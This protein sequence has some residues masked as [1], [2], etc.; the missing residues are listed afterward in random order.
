MR[1][2]L[3]AV[4]A[5]V[6]ALGLSAAL[7]AASGQPAGEAIRALL[8]GGTGSV[9]AFLGSASRATPLLLTGP[10]VAVALTAGR[11]NIGAEGQLAVGALVAATTAANLPLP[12]PLATAVGLILGAVSGGLWAIP[13]SW[14]RERRGI[15]EVITTLLL[16]YVARN[17]T[18]FLASGPW[19]E[20]SGQAPQTAAIPWPLPRLD[21]SGGVHVGL[22]IALPVAIVVSVALAHSVA[23][24]E[25]RWVGA[26][27]EAARRAGIPVERWRH[28]AFALSGA[29][30]GLAGGLVVCG[31]TP[32]RRFPADF[33]GVGYGF[34]G[35]AIAL[36]AA[37]SPLALAPVAFLFAALGEGA[38]AMEFET[39]TPRQLGQ[40]VEALVVLAVSA[41]LVLGRRR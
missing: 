36:M 4:A 7:L 5:L 32:F 17:L 35:L 38:R 9:A 21:A 23:G 33:Y 29:L 30:C 3:R 10:A 28:R 11:F 25:L 34:D 26:G 12:G 20:P 37:G 13:A 16:N 27:A 39:G 1:S 8:L 40:V 14:L 31:A 24:F 2:M 19:R 22:W 18:H 6:V 15:H 41:R